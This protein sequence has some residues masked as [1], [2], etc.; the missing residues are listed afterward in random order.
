MAIQHSFYEY[1]MIY[2]GRCW[3]L[4]VLPE[5]ISEMRVGEDATN[6][7]FILILGH[8][9]LDH[10]DNNGAIAKAGK[11][12]ELSSEN[13]CLMGNWVTYCYETWF[14][15]FLYFLRKFQAK[16]TPLTNALDAYLL[17]SSNYCIFSIHTGL[18]RQPCI[19]QCPCCNAACIH[20]RA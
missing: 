19:E 9:L 13:R 14:H 11:R 15:S 2:S 8:N 12:R 16:Q 7:D 10:G 5:V 1:F 3:Y 20:G 4:H 17:F 18:G 6:P